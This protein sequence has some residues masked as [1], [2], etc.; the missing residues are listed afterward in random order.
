MK[1]GTMQKFIASAPGKLSLMGD[2]SVVYGEPCL[3]T[4]VD[5]RLRVTVERIEEEILWLEAPDVKVSSYRKNLTEL[6]QGELPKSV[7]FIEKSYALFTAEFG[8]TKGGIK[9]TT[10]S[11]FSALF[12][13][14]SSSASAVAFLQAVAAAF[15]IELT[16]QKLFELAYRV[17]L[18]IQK[19]GS[20]FDIA[21][22]I[23]GGTL[24]YVTPAKEVKTLPAEE[25]PLVVCYTGVKAD[26][27]TLIKQLAAK[28]AQNPDEING[29]FSQITQ[30][31]N[32]AQ[33]AIETQN[34][35]KLGQL[36]TQNHELLVKLGVSSPVLDTLCATAIEAGAW[37]AKLSGAGGGDC[38]IAVVSPEKKSAVIEALTKVGGQVLPVHLHASGVRIE[39]P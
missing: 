14:G 15:E 39:Q 7:A 37:G 11:D 18:D 32:A 27:A 8:I 1:K 20:G 33:T 31:V 28:R 12:G 22:A 36:F 19:V 17:V 10:Q 30:L 23:W 34:W 21:A 3:V 25:L 6:G 4:A 9:V 26:T 29:I 35:S 2:H 13:F 5:Q 16:P 38:M 24:R